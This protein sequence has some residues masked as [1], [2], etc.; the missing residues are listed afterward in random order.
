MVEL[1][2]SLQSTTAEAEDTHDFDDQMEIDGY[3]LLQRLGHGK[4]GIAYLAL[5]RETG[6]PVCVKVFRDRAEALNP[7]TAKSFQ[8]EI[9]A[10]NA[11]FDHPHVI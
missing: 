4:F 11:G 3:R 6:E 2:Q 7:E 8:A 5:G 9:E 1:G 10:G